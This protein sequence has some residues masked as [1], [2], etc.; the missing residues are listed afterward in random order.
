MRVISP[1][2]AWNAKRW[3]GASFL[4][5]GQKAVC[6]QSHSLM[7][8]GRG[9]CKIGVYSDPIKVQSPTKLK[10]SLLVA[11]DDLKPGLYGQT[12]AITVTD[13]GERGL[14]GA[15]V[16]IERGTFGWKRAELVFDVPPRT[17]VVKVFIQLMGS[18]RMWVDNVSLTGAKLDANTGLAWSDTDKK[19][20]PDSPI[21]TESPQLLAKVAKA[22]ESLKALEA[23]V[24]AAKAKGV[25]TLYDEIPLGAGQA[26]VRDTLGFARP[27]GAA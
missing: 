9:A 7:L 19:V 3:Q 6:E 21:V 5:V 11:G 14:A 13:H 10:L 18:G 26:G 24:A 15:E 23:A 1:F 16:K 20:T 8:D 4:G 27:S 25:E 2:K 22:K 17:P 12:A